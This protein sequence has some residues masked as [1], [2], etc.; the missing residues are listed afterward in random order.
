MPEHYELLFN[1]YKVDGSNRCLIT[2]RVETDRP[3]NRERSIYIKYK[4]VLDV[5]AW[6]VKLLSTFWP[7]KI[8]NTLNSAIDA[9]KDDEYTEQSFKVFHI[10]DAN[11]IRVF[12]AEYAIPVEN[13]TWIAAIDR[14]ME[15]AERI[16]REKKQYLTVPVAVRFV[17]G[18]R[19]LLS[20]MYGR[21][22]CMLEVIGLRGVKDTP[23]ILE[24]IEWALHAHAVRPHWGQ[25]NHITPDQLNEMYPDSI[26]RWRD[27]H[28]Q[29]NMFRTFTNG[30]S[31]RVGM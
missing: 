10:G 5:S 17:K 18:T 6:W 19:A 7:S 16:G 24:Q 8:K 30:F 11:E 29:L 9:L 2:T 25:V 26:G 31:R 15:V 27:V 22:T 1:P 12:S 14:L 20:P 28:N 23:L 4:A 3:G 21:D 13:D